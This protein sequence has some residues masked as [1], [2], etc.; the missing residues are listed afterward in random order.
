MSSYL[1]RVFPINKSDFNFFDCQW[2]VDVFP[3]LA[4]VARRERKRVSWGS[5][6][7][8]ECWVGEENEI[9][10]FS[11]ENKKRKIF[12]SFRLSFSIYRENSVDDSDSV[13]VVL[14]RSLTKC[15]AMKK[16]SHRA[17]IPHFLL[18]LRIKKYTSRYFPTSKNSLSPFSVALNICIDKG[19]DRR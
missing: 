8:N 18:S 17:L 1:S 4:S 14:K 15:A 5:E 11:A 16:I 7:V 13:H 2:A 3:P 9:F 6:K 19:P 10:H 12:P